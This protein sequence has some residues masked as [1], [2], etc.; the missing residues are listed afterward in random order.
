MTHLSV[1]V[2]KIALL[3]NSRPCDRPNP[4]SFAAM[5]LD[6]GAQGITVHPR[7]DQRHVRPSDVTSIQ[8]VLTAANAARGEGS[9]ALELNIE[10]NPFET[11][12][13]ALVERTRPEQATLVPDSREQATSD[14]G[15]AMPDDLEA[16]RQI[17]ARLQRVGCRVSVFM[18]PDPVAIEQ[19]AATGA[20]RIEL[21][22][23]AYAQAFLAGDRPR[24]AALKQYAEAARAATRVNLGVNAGHDLDQANLPAFL[25]HV[26][27]VLEVSI[28]HAL[29]V[30]ALLAGWQ[31]TIQG[32][33][34]ICD[35]SR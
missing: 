13:M 12:W 28:G 17:V 6:A 7:P 11:E 33:R 8:Q 20:E 10:G 27:N 25:K 31:T 15:F 26:P 34:S 18:D 22:T 2:N 16:L 5:A 32:Y 30:E 14:H 23:E 35:G 21:Y 4:A 24:E 29:T 19:V 1:N 9:S 3:R